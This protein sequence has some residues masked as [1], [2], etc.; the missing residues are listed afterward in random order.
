[1]TD[2]PDV[3][4]NRHAAHAEAGVHAGG[5]NLID[6]AADHEYEDTAGLIALDGFNSFFNARRGT[7]HNDKARDVARNQRN[8]QLANLSVGEMTVI[9][10]SLIG[11]GGAGVLARF[12]DLR[13]A[14]GGDAG[15]E[16]RL[17]AVFATHHIAKLAERFLQLAQLA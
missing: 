10:R 12:D 2:G 16:D 9:L 17:R 1:M 15:I 3:R 4:A 11:R 5:V 13:A 14:R 6:D 8:A 7:D